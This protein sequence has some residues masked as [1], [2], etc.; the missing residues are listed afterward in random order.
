MPAQTAC[1]DEIAILLEAYDDRGMPL[2][3]VL[4]DLHWSDVATLT[5]IAVAGAA[6][7]ARPANAIGTYR[8]V[9][10]IVRGHSLKAVKHELLM[11][12]QCTGLRA[13]APVS[14]ARGRERPKSAGLYEAIGHLIRGV[15]ILNRLPD[16]PKRARQEL[17][18]QA[19]LGLALM[20]TKGFA[21]S[22]VG[23]VNVRAAKLC[24][25]LGEPVQLCRCCGN[26]DNT[27]SYEAR[28][29]PPMNWQSGSSAS[30]R[31]RRTRTS[32]CK[33]ILPLQAL[34]IACRQCAKTLELQ[35]GYELESAVAS[36][37]YALRG[38]PPVGRYPQLV[39]RGV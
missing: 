31:Q 1:C 13:C 11:H 34:N 12:R 6:A 10:A 27:I 24:Q 4:E 36:P 5:C 18:F 7:P 16:T 8:P 32:S 37:E 38:T 9:E 2:V 28:H 15:E 39:H 29:E 23:T 22:E 17:D 19:S 21:A 20:L 14:A 3:L 26:C 25:Q 33:P 30:P 35:G